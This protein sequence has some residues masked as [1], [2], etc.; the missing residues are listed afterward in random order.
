MAN[1]SQS[2][3]SRPT[4]RPAGF[5]KAAS[6]APQRHVLFGQLL[7][8]GPARS[9]PIFDRLDPAGV[10]RIVTLLSHDELALLARLVLA[11]ARVERATSFDDATLVAL[12]RAATRL[13][14]DR[15]LATLPQER[16]DALRRVTVEREAP[17]AAP[18]TARPGRADQG[19]G[20][21]LRLRRLFR[22]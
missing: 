15:L 11:P 14:G 7:R 10:A 16:A 12:S 22:L 5:V 20:V 2:A 4:S 21:V 18:V 6:A 3:G 9:G 1:V 8:A 17:A 13:D 19:L